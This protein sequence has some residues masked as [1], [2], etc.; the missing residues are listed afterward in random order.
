M[1]G[2]VKRLHGLEGVDGSMAFF[3]VRLVKVLKFVMRVL[4]VQQK[5]LYLHS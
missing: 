2:E 1:K 5:S 3:W 4:K